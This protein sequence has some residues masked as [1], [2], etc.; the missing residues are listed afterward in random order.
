MDLPAALDLGREA[1]LTAL[2]VAAPVLGTGVVVGIIISL[3]QVIT[4]L[5]DQTLSIAPKI[6][7][8]LGAAIFFV[9]WLGMRMIEFM[10]SMFAG[11]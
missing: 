7:A 11:W 4:Q 1:L 3:V 9:P 2:I 6:V 5:Q 10:R 8:M